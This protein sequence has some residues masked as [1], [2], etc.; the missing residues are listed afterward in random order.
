MACDISMS[1]EPIFVGRQRELARLEEC[2]TLALSGRGQVSLLAGEAGAGKSALIQE[3]TR[4]VQED[5]KDLVAAAG[6]CNNLD[7]KGDPYLPFREVLA[8]LTGDIEAG[9][10]QGSLTT[11]N[12]GRLSKLIVESGQILV[13]VAPD[14]INIVIPGSRVV[15]LA[16][17][18][19]ARRAGWLDRLD[20][21][22][23]MEKPKSSSGEPSMSP[24]RIFE[25]Y[26]A[27]LARLSDSTPLVITIDDLQWM[28]NASLGLFFHLVRKIE[29][30]R[31]LLLGAYRPDVMSLARDGERHPLGPILSEITRYHGD[32]TIDLSS[33]ER[34]EGRSFVDGLLDAEPNALDEAFREALYERTEGHP[35]FTVEL[36]RALKEAGDIQQD[37]SGRWTADPGI[38]WSALPKRVE[39]VVA[40]RIARIDESD[41]KLL[42][43]ASVEGDSFTAEVVAR[44]LKMDPRQIV[45]RLSSALS[46]GQGLVV[47]A[48]VRRVGAQRLS[49]YSFRHRLFQQYLYESMDEAERTYLHEDVAQALIDLYG[50]DDEAIIGQLA[51]HS[52]MAG[53]AEQA[54]KYAVMAGDRAY[55]VFASADAAEYYASAVE[56]LDSVEAGTDNLLHL[57]LNHGRA[58]ELSGQNR[59]ALECYEQ[60]ERVAMDRE[61]K[62]L[63]L[64]SLTAR[65]VLQSIPTSAHDPD[66]S[67]RLATR[68]LGLAREVSDADSEARIL[69]CLMLIEWYSG[70]PAE[71]IVSGEESL[72]IAR[73]LGRQER[74]AFTLQ[75]LAPSYWALGQRDKARASLAEARTL[76]QEL[77]NQPMLANALGGRAHFEYL[78]GEYDLA[79]ELADESLRISREIGNLSGVSFGQTVLGLLHLEHGALGR[80]VDALRQAVDRGR[81]ADNALASTAVKAEL[82]WALSCVGAIDEG[83]ALAGQALAE[84]QQHYPN[85][86]D[87]C[88]A[89]DARIRLQLPKGVPISSELK[90]IDSQVSKID[91]ATTLVLAGPTVAAAA[92]EMAMAQ[93]DIHAAL[94]RSNM[95]LS[96]LD[97]IGARSGLPHALLL[98]SRILQGQGLADRAR[99]ALEEARQTA[100]AM[101]AR[102]SLWMILDGLA[103]LAEDQG[104]AQASSELRLQAREIVVDIAADIDREAY[105]AS[106]L[107]LPEITRLMTE[108]SPGNPLSR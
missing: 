79:R 47:G 1:G 14:L 57:F 82:G 15:A 86:V 97:Q 39:G 11:T 89:I 44:V 94:S 95:Q 58:L 13:D 74:L 106:F 40:E 71:A 5:H 91:P 41:R 34:A 77:G 3:F 7:G 46:R 20:A 29:T 105:R 104:D 25:E 84:A 108:Q 17:K 61:D 88:R 18:A 83:L 107:G 70:H 24:E 56:I 4:R 9:L 81:E 10:T 62:R 31:I 52:G 27:F 59:R 65:S 92:V 78:A 36:I 103:R 26:A 98:R 19:V 6:V 28:D 87:W 12:A 16:G 85:A 42:E 73:R 96:Y 22:T 23:K 60:L 55:S 8:M 21:L 102:Y 93:G 75:D 76:W 35:L 67:R 45:G 80:A 2:L 101:G 49:A 33:V 69:W 54:F 90:G 64:A 32:A 30:H 50:E 99:E 48:G 66:E 38:D 63:H 43:V 72:D 37:E 100:E 51:Y 53:V 68:A